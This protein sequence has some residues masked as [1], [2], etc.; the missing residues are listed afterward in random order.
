MVGMCEGNK[1]IQWPIPA[2][3][4]TGGSLILDMSPVLGTWHV[5]ICG[6]LANCLFSPTQVDLLWFFWSRYVFSPGIFKY[7][8]KP[9]ASHAIRKELPEQRGR[10][11]PRCEYCTLPSSGISLANPQE[12]ASDFI[13]T[14]PIISNL[15]T[16]LNATNNM[17]RHWQISRNE[18]G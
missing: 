3:A 7:T 1:V 10:G 18:K 6:K 13:R 11:L 12:E 4:A 16:M 9:C 14:H 17:C 8:M 2:C 15:N 5:N